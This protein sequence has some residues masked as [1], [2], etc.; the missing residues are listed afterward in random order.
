MVVY[1]ASF[2]MSLGPIMWLII[3]E[4]FPLNIRGVG[5][6]LAI[7]VSWAFNMFVALTFLSLIQAI[8]PGHTFWLYASLCILGGFFVYFLV[9]ET[10]N[11]SL[12][13]IEQNLR[14]GRPS[15]ELG[16]PS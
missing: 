7:A 13:H 8:G 5:A 16:N 12:E 9:P 11:C 2:A 10:K 4:I 3:S 6:S 1:I 15:R 14:A